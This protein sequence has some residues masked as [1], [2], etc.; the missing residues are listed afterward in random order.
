MQCKEHLNEFGSTDYKLHTIARFKERFNINLSNDEYNDLTNLCIYIIKRDD[1]KFNKSYKVSISFKYEI[2]TC[3][4]SKKFK[5]KT[6]FPHKNKRMKIKIVNKSNNL[7]PAYAKVGDSGMDLRADFTNG[8]NENFMFGTAFDEIRQTLLVFS[9]GRCLVPTGIYTSFPPGYEIQIRPRSGLSLKKGIH[10]A[11]GTIDS[12]YRGEL[13]VILTNFGDDV[14][15]I[16][17][18]DKI[19]QAVLAKVSL[20]E[21]EEVEELDS[22]DRKGGFG[23][24]G[25]K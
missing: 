9:G 20:I 12:C 24:T 19:A 14:F 8:L 17:Q 15:E 13:G 25:V 6:V 4:I 10:I 3:I 5:L 2:I 18:G 16:Q 11:L 7:L 1:I 22:T 21:W 23:H